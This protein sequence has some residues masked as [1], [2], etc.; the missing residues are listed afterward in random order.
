MKTIKSLGIVLGLSL[1][2]SNVFG[3][4]GDI[5]S[6]KPYKNELWP[7]GVKGL[8]N[9]PNRVHGLFVN[10]ADYFYFE[11]NK[12]MFL[13]F[14]RRY[15]KVQIDEHII[16]VKEGSPIA[17]SPWGEEPGKPCDWMMMVVPRNW[18]ERDRNANGYVVEITVWAE[19]R[20]KLE[21]LQLPDGI[22]IVENE[23]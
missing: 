13:N 10:A 4:G 19:G 17:K 23:D 18:I 20:I 11:G 12:E 1:M 14:L 8:V 21:G 22:E 3:L 6:D 16:R 2:I 9:T 15:S 5:P 7:E